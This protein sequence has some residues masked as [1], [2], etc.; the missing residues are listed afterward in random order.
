MRG[1]AARQ[2]DPGETQFFIS[3]EDELMVFAPKTI[4]KMMEKFGFKEDEAI[5]HSMISKSIEA[6]QS[7][8]EGMNFDIRKHVLEYDDVLNKQRQAIYA[9]RQAF[10]NENE[11]LKIKELCVSL[12]FEK[13]QKDIKNHGNDKESFKN[14]INNLKIEIFDEEISGIKNN[15]EKASYLLMEKIKN[16]YETKAK[17]IENFSQISKNVAL[18]I[19]DNLW[20]IHLEKMQQLRDSVLLKAYANVEP[21]VV[22]KKDSF[23]F[24]QNL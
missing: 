17:T 4:G 7:K 20:M 19:L 12:I 11:D 2:G 10:L 1:R 9:K 14:Y 6:A 24:Y 23:I 13:I 22:Y 5:T 3:L 21:I 18:S 15:Q 16:I 8:I